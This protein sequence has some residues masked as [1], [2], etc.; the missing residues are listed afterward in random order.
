MAYPKEELLTLPLEER[1]ELASGL[2]DSILADELQP[3]ADW[4]TELVRERISLNKANPTD[5]IEWAELRKKYFAKC[6]LGLLLKG[7]RKLTWTK[8]LF[9]MKRSKL[10]WGLNS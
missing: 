10:V 6:V 9:G 3:M 1:R 5:G 4:K 7:K 8:Y 2:I